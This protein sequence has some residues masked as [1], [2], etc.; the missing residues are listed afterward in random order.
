MNF[1][2]ERDCITMVL[3]CFDEKDIKRLDTLPKDSIRPE[4]NSQVNKIR[5]KIFTQCGPKKLNG[6]YLNSR[7]YLKMVAEYVKSINSGSVPMIQN[8][9]QN[10]LEN[11]C[12]TALETAKETYDRA[13]AQRF[14]EK[15]KALRKTELNR[16]LKELRDQANTAFNVINSV[17]ES[18]EDMFD[19][20][21]NELGKH[22]E[23]KE[24]IQT[25]QNNNLSD[26]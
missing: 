1:F 23:R 21:F 14:S 25:D 18:D 5:N 19:K 17:K 2:R 3:P 22:I 6:T 26:Q 16:A 12:V 20:Y 9:W 8:A 7:M 13:F 10:V 11:E 15:N 24:K 4:F